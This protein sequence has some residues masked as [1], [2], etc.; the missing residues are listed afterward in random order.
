MLARNPQTDF[1]GYSVPHPGEPY[2]NVR[3]QTRGP[4]VEEMVKDSLTALGDI[5]D[6][7]SE[8]FEEEFAKTDKMAD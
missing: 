2:L 4:P 7:I 8:V 1:I 5:C 3:L 6:H